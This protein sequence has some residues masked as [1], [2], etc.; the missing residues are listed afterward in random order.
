ML[1]D[2]KAELARL[3]TDLG[4]AKRVVDDAS[5]PNT[6]VEWDGPMIDVWHRIVDQANKHHRLPNLVGVATKD[7]PQSAILQRIR[8]A[9]FYT[10]SHRDEG[11]S[12]VAPD[13]DKLDEVRRMV[14]GINERVS[15]LQTWQ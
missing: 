12:A 1:N 4:S 9:L 10:G 6:L 7:Y 3:Y 15:V 2:L 14:Y 13:E 11:T 5:I 8:G